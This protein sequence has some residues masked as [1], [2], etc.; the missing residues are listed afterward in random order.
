MRFVRLGLSVTSALFFFVAG[1]QMREQGS[2]VDFPFGLLAYGAAFAILSYGTGGL[3]DATP[4]PP[5]P[6]PPARSFYDE[7]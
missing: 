4:T 2:G 6:S 3:R 1:A 7:A 5:T